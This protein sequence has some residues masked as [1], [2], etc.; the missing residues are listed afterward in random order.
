MGECEAS[1]A[2]DATNLGGARQ[3]IILPGARAGNAPPRPLFRLPRAVR[4]QYSPET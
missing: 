2:G 3:F 4:R 1:I